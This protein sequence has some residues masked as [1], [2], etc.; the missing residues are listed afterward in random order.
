MAFGNREV[1]RSLSCRFPAGRISVILGGSGSGKSTILRMVGGLVHPQAGRVTV[2][3]TDITRLSEKQM[4]ATRRSIGMMF[5][6]GALLDSLTVFD[7]LAFPLRE[8]TRKTEVEI[9]DAVH[10]TL[11]AVGLRNADGLLPGQLS[12]GMVKR[13]ALARAIIMDP[14]IL[15]CDEPFSG[16]DPISSKRIEILLVGINRRSKMTVLMVSHNIAS[17]MRIADQVILL[18]P[19]GAVSGSPQQLGASTDPRIASFLTEDVDESLVPPEE[20]LSVP[21]RIA[22]R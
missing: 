17:T 21:P 11:E 14:V 10:R 15:L 16:L 1:F 2:A 9:T 12:G 19:G 4:Y 6:G 20:D 13:V 22:V 8:H 18:L 7:N 5:Q 3:G